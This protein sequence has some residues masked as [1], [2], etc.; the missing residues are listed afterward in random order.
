MVAGRRARRIGRPP[1]PHPHLA[2]SMRTVEQAL[3]DHLVAGREAL[4]IE[5]SGEAAVRD[6]IAEAGEPRRLSNGRYRIENTVECVV[7]RA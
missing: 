1:Y 5:Q 4:A 7:T 6:A 2:A 3:G